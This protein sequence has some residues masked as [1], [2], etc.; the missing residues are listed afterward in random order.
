VE[1]EELE[2]NEKESFE[3]MDSGGGPSSLELG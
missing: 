3:Q 1:E 2:E